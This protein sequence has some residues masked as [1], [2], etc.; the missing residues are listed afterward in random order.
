MT[1]LETSERK[2]GSWLD[3]TLNIG[4]R[5]DLETILIAVLILAAISPKA[6]VSNTRL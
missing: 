6:G 1:T 2:S 3:R 5:L 4:V